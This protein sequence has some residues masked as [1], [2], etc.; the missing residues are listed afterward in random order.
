MNWPQARHRAGERTHGQSWL[1]GASPWVLV[2]GAAVAL[3]ALIGWFVNTGYFLVLPGQALSTSQMV[4]VPGS[5]P[6]SQPGELLLVT[7]YS[8]PANADEWLLSHVYPNAHLEPAR[9]QLPPNTSYESFRHIEEAMMTDSQTAAKVAALRQLGYD[10]P[11]H[12]K[13]VVV[14]GVRPGTPA[15][16]A[17]LH[18][19]DLIVAAAGQPLET[20]EQLIRLVGGM[21][22]GDQLELRLKP[23]NS[24]VE[25]AL[26]VTLGARPGQPRTGYLGIGTLTFQPRYDFPVAV[27]IDS[28]G[29]IGPSAGLVLTLSIMQALSPTDLTH[30][31]KIA[32]TGT[33]DLQGNV[34]PVGGVHDKVIAADNRADYFLVP[35]ADYAE[36]TAQARHMRVV[37]V[38]TLQQAVDFLNGLG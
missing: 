8:A 20:D 18:K 30:G 23:N 11:Q 3:A 35:K 2:P 34:G 21:Q 37:E 9:T 1:A 26:T 22:P 29:I 14:D 5:A 36:A 7:I 12:G 16:A 13:G 33:I 28:K 4:S 32:A 25:T 24:E 19:G 31:H 38:D 27:S 17:G 10:V 6:K 15:E